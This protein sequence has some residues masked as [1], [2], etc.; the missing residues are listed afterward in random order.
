MAA[1]PEP[2][3][4][5]RVVPTADVADVESDHDSVVG[6]WGI[7][8]R[9]VETSL[10]VF[11][12]RP[13][14][15]CPLTTAGADPVCPPVSVGLLGVRHW[16]GRNLALNVGAAL[17]LGGGSE[18]G[19]LLDSYLGLGPEV[20][21]SVLLGNWKH[22][23][24]LASPGLAFIWFKA[25]GSA[26]ATYV[27]DMRADLEAELHFGFIGVPALSLGIRSGVLFRLEHTAEIS[28]WSTEVAGATSLRGL[29]SDLLL[30]YYF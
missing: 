3:A 17:A 10:P 30:R 26:D 19:R 23:A 9:R 13:S 6:A 5:P 14:T 29:V 22:L 24:V 11:A 2:P 27:F 15:G 12:R 28:V 25:A 20:G 16:L 8:V 18:R 7:E 21:V 4:P 1:P